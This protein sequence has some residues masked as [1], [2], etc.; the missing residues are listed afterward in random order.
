MPDGRR[1]LT[2]LLAEYGPLCERC[3]SHHARLTLSQVAALIE[4]LRRSIAFRVEHGKCPECQ[5]FTKTFVL[6]KTHSG[7]T[8]DGAP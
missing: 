7:P 3:L 4:I 8:Q 6:A 5:Q 2:V 1:V